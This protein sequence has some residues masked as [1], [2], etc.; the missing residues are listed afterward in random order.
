[1]STAKKKKKK[2]KSRSSKFAKKYCSSCRNMQKSAA[3]KLNKVDVAA[4]RTSE[5][6]VNVFHSPKGLTSL[7][8]RSLLKRGLPAA[9]E[10]T[11][12]GE[13]RERKK[14]THTLGKQCRPM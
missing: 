4:K 13:K 14:V 2:K 9:K 8:G 11:C 10:K 7:L 3:R 6:L 1:M 12:S 5:K